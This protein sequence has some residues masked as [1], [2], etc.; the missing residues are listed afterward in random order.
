MPITGGKKDAVVAEKE[1][2]RNIGILAHIDAGKTT[3]TERILYYTGRNYKIGEV[4]S[5]DTVMD[6]MPEE[7]ERGITITSAATSCYWRDHIVNIIDTPGHIDFSVEVERSLRVLDGAVMVLCGVA[8]VQPQT[9]KVWHQIRKFRIPTIFFVNKMDRRGADFNRDVDMIRKR[10]GV[11][12]VV[13]QM[14]FGEG[15]DFAGIIDLLLMKLLVY[16]GETLGKVY[17]AMDIPADWLERAMSARETMLEAIAEIDDAIAQAFLDGHDIPMEDLIAAIRRGTIAGEISPVVL[18][19][20]FKNK[21]V[22]RLMDGVVDFLPAPE[23]L[24]PIKG[25]DPEKSNGK[26]VEVLRDHSPD[27]PF[28][29]L[30]FKIIHDKHLQGDTAFVRVYS[31]TIRAKEK[32]YNPVKNKVERI[33][34]LVRIHADNMTSID[35]AKAGDI[36]GIVGLKYTLTGDTLCDQ[37][38]PVILETIEIPK[39]VV[40]I[41]VEPETREQESKL[42]E[43]LDKVTRE[44]P[45][46]NYRTNEETN[47]TIVSGMGELHLSVILSRLKREFGLS[48]RS[49]KPR[50]AYRQTIRRAVRTEGKYIRQSGGRGQYGHVVIDVEPLERGAGVKFEERIVGGVVPREFFPA[51]QKGIEEAAMVGINAEIPVVDVKV[52]L[53]DGS[54]HTVDS[55]ELAFKV[56]ASKAFKQA[57]QQGS[58]VVLEPVMQLEVV[59][60]DE[61]VGGVIGF[62]NSRRGRITSLESRGG[63]QEL[64]LEIPLAD[65]FG[66]ASGLRGLTKGRGT[67]FMRFANYQPVPDGMI[68][69]GGQA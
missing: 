38:H 43:V 60:P 4:H 66:L 1:G 28:A 51:V 12:P 50:V 40:E 57:V 63:V 29:G 18:G 19:S 30:A 13:T 49:G 61:Y 34:R 26:P 17:K 11:K 10:L 9:E 54:F 62:L 55:S 69:D 59:V 65:T 42:F 32:I 31:G 33:A 21:G 37:Q 14:P 56:A 15:P 5:G 23:D 52:T 67:H 16:E 27:E 39:P 20:A 64:K 22:Q 2:I 44:D 36:V 25:I 7:R 3:T 48:V 68:V 58:P 46:F 6:F 45:S 41:A 35:E 8:G 53:V 24:E 47:Q